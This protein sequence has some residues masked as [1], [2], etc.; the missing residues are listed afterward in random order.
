MHGF[1]YM[2]AVRYPDC[3][4]LQSSYFGKVQDF[5]IPLHTAL[6]PFFAASFSGVLTNL[7]FSSSI[8][9]TLAL[10]SSGELQPYLRISHRIM[11]LEGAYKSIKS[12][13]KR[14]CF[15]H[16]LPL[17]F[18]YASCSTSNMLFLLGFSHFLLI[19]LPE[20]EE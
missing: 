15:L 11:E 5:D 18:S 10:C 12:N 3:F 7:A 8:C 17:T 16:F 6:S 20:L 2:Y 13:M 9:K 1:D 4:F 19:S 14:I